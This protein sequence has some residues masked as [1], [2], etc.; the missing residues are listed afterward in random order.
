MAIDGVK[1]PGEAEAEHRAQKEHP[2]NH[3][4]L[5][6]GHEVHVWSE[7]GQDSQK[8]KQHKTYRKGKKNN[9]EEKGNV[10][11]DSSRCS[12][13]T[14]ITGFSC[15]NCSLNLNFRRKRDPSY[16]PKQEDHFLK[17]WDIVLTMGTYEEE[18]SASPRDRCDHERTPSSNFFSCF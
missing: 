8:E 14:K 18:G 17:H 9:P 13:S 5:Q 6:R 10:H 15:A 12:V 4:L 11:S 16:K 3:L 7:H 1:E 2:E